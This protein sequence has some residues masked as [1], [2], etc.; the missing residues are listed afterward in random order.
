MSQKSCSYTSR[1]WHRVMKH[2]LDEL[3]YNILM[4]SISHLFP[5]GLNLSLVAYCVEL[6][7]YI[8]LEVKQRINSTHFC[9]EEFNSACLCSDSLEV[10]NHKSKT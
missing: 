10:Y 2:A 3:Q 8:L 1:S 9:L 6:Y 5:D 4:Y 7:T